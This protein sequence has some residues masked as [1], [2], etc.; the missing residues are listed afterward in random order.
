MHALLTFSYTSTS[1]T[2]V[3]WPVSVGNSISIHISM[4][5]RRR[6]S[7]VNIAHI[8]QDEEDGAAGFK[9]TITFSA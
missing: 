6:H 8:Q 5:T 9:V 7:S 2:H 4:Q 3:V 1:S